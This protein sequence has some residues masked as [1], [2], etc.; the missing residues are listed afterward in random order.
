M[1]AYP[2]PFG[3]KICCALAFAIFAP[4]LHSQAAINLALNPPSL[5]NDYVGKLAITITGLSP[6]QTVKVK[7]YCD[8]NGNGVIDAGQDFAVRGFGVTDGGLPLF[9]GV[10][11]R[12]IPGDDDGAINGQIV[13]NLDFPGVEPIFGGAAGTFIIAIAD[14][15]TEAVLASQSFTVVQKTQGQAVHGQITATTSGLALTNGFVGLI[16]SSNSGGTVAMVDSN[17]NYTLFG[18]PGDYTVIPIFKGYVADNSIGQVTLPANQ[19]ITNNQALNSGTLAVTG[20]VADSSTGK[21]IGAIFVQ[22]ETQNN[23]FAATFTDTNGNYRLLLTPGQWKLRLNRQALAEKGYLALQNGFSTNFITAASNL[24]VL[25]PKATALLYGT[26]TD[27]ATHPVAGIGV[28]ATSMDNSF[29]ADGQTMPDGTFCLGVI[30]ANW[31][32]SPNGDD[33][34]P[35]G[36]I[37]NQGTNLTLADSAAAQVQFVAQRAASHLSGQVHDDQGTPISNI[38]IVVSPSNDPNGGIYPS[39]DANGNFDVGVS[40]GA[41]TISLECVS[42]QASGYV[43]TY[44]NY[45]VTDGVDQNGLQL[46]FPMATATLSGTIKDSQNNPV[47]G[48]DLD[49][50]DTVG[51]SVGCVPT[52]ANGN[53][54]LK[55]LPGTWTLSV[56]SD[57]LAGLGYGLVASTNIVITGNSGSASFVVQKYAPIQ[58]TTASLPG[59]TQGQPYTAVLAVTGGNPPYTWSFDSGFLQSG[60]ALNTATGQISGT[61]GESGSFPITLRVTDSSM[62]TTN[63]SFSIIAA[64]GSFPRPLL[65][66]LTTAGNLHPALQLKGVPGQTYTIEATTNLTTWLPLGSFGVSTNLMPLIDPATL[67]QFHQRFYRAHVGRAFSSSFSLLCYI[68]GGSFGQSLIP[69]LNIPAQINSYAAALDIYNDPSFPQPAAVLF[70]GPAGSGVNNLAANF[71][72]AHPSSFGAEQAYFQTPHFSPLAI[73]GSW[74]V[75]YHGSNLLYAVA[76]IGAQL[77]LP[78]PTVTLLGGQLQSVTWVYK[79]PTTGATLSQAPSNLAQIQIQV[80]DTLHSRVYN[81]PMLAPSAGSHTFSTSLDWSSISTIYMAC[82]DPSGNQYVVSFTKP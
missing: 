10:R 4:F 53:F 33:L 1:K 71:S 3:F 73:S 52:D 67:N 38:T 80:D 41:W 39:T 2:S 68:N 37:S 81:S 36:Y 65:T 9:G 62:G 66:N 78:V 63:K 61:P 70:T 69:S 8:F 74:T 48:V 15:T 42:A 30:G 60:L 79:N 75:S 59:A 45:T 54:S 29:E 55:V 7:R 46:T 72:V 24:N 27:A 51:H 35:Y 77:V 6:G 26:L 13:V 23:L 11:N 12:N 43:N 25:L 56:S 76:N 47:V 64:S 22:A 58:I 16:P 19:W 49:A 50:N 82:S 18:A 5:T 44:Y 31:N 17:G 21:G 14:P 40:A 34:A 28:A 32:V 57:E 20:Q